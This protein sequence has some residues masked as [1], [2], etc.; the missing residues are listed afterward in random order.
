[1]NTPTSPELNTKD[2][3]TVG[4]IILI[5]VVSVILCLM[6]AQRTMSQPNI[7][8]GAKMAVG[9]GTKENPYLVPVVTLGQEKP[10]EYKLTEVQQLKLQVQQKDAQLLQAQ[11]QNIQ[12]QFQEK[13]SELMSTAQKIKM[14]NGWSPDTKF[15][16]DHLIF[17]APDPKEEVKKP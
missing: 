7:P 2:I 10:K 1:M 8:K 11:L 3:R 12:R 17:S 6:W 5:G 13:V 16:P 4:I 14:E 15:D 9:E